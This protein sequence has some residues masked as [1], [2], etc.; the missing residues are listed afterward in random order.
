[1]TPV[2][3]APA[4]YNP[5]MAISP[6]P[7]LLTE[8]AAGRMVILVDEED[9]ENEGDLVVAADHVTADTINFMARFGRGLI[10]LTLTRE[11]CER[12]RLPPMALKNGAQHG[13]AFTVSIEAAVG[14]TTGISA[15]DRARTVQAAVARDAQAGD[16]VQPGHIFPLQAQD[17][18]V[19]MR[20]GHT[21]AG[22]D[23]SAM[24]G[25][26]PASVICEIMNDD[27]TMARLPDLEVFAQQHGLKIGT[28][29][30]LIEYRS[31]NETLIERV[32]QRMLMTA[33]GEFSCTS[34]ADRAG[35]LHLALTRG[36]WTARD[37]VLVR[38]HEPLSVMDLLDAGP[39]SHSWPL[40]QALA[41]LHASERG[42]AVLLN[43]GENTTSLLEKLNPAHDASARRAPPMDLRTYGIGAQILR[44][45]GVA[46]MKLLGSPRR[47]PSM[48][49]YGLEVIGF[50]AADASQG[51]DR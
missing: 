23:L 7:E 37:E 24:A 5:S 6:I 45:M 8:L 39:C 16:L 15:A 46:K 19:L 10:C 12:L 21:E 31:R 20:A 47:M 4:T 38:V 50:I 22:C 27:G 18:G 3:A 43:C 11:R 32:G 35:G 33:Q 2:A 1:L 36:Q 44:D 49:G 9:R 30:D 13:T 17:G 51:T 42:I 25:L 28:I 40:P 29:A 34:F 14:V 41:Q 26:S 48:V